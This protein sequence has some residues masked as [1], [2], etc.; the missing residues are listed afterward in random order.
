MAR[1]DVYAVPPTNVSDQ[2]FIAFQP[3]A[4][5]E[6]VLHNIYVPNGAGVEL[7]WSDGTNDI[8]IDSGTESYNDWKFH[9]TNTVYVRLKN[10]SGGD[11]RIGGDGMYTK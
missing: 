2:A 4:P 6:I 5:A 3:I 7:Y 10:V 9:C 11:I 1:G 8:L